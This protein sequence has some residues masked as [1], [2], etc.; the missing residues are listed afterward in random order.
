MLKDVKKKEIMSWG[1][2][3]SSSTAPT[4]TM[5]SSTNK[6]LV[7][8][9]LG[10]ATVLKSVG[11][12]GT[13]WV[14]P[15]PHPKPACHTSQSLNTMLATDCSGHSAARNSAPPPSAAPIRTATA[16]HS[17]FWS[18]GLSQALS[19]RPRTAGYPFCRVKRQHPSGLLHHR[20][21]FIEKI[22]ILAERVKHRFLAYSTN[23][24]KCFP[25]PQFD[26]MALRRSP[27]F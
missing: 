22:T 4:V 21:H 17:T 10:G 26:A 11:T 5:S 6:L 1:T 14:F 20:G 24:R 9:T 25:C 19:W 3:P 12:T 27:F 8:S 23:R 2:C 16:N 18:W 13:L 7:K 15:S